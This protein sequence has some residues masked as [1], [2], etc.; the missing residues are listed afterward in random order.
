MREKMLPIA[1][2]KLNLLLKTK[3]K[4]ALSNAL[5]KIREVSIIM[6]YKK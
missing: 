6:H 3:N 5:N 1:F 4:L 2:S